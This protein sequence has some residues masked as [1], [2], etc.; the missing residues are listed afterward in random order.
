MAMKLELLCDSG[1][2]EAHDFAPESDVIIGRGKDCQLR[3][4]DHE[5]SREHSRIF[6]TNG[7]AFLADMGSTNGT[8]V[9][10]ESEEGRWTAFNMELPAAPP[11]ASKPPTA[12][13]RGPVLKLK[14]D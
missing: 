11:D 6:W 14:Q 3:L 1:I 13:A 10:V 8:T 5:S 4:A 7:R 9:S 2:S 12:E